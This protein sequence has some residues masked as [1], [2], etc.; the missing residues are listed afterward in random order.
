MKQ[1]EQDYKILSSFKREFIILPAV[2]I[3][4]FIWLKFTHIGIPCVFRLLT[5]WKCPGCGITH[6]FMDLFQGKLR[7]A[8]KENSFLMLTWPFIIGECIALSKLKR[9]KKK[10]PAWN[11][12]M[13]Y[14]YIAVACCFGVLRN[15][16]G[17]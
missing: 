9:E 12:A 3:A 1:S 16:Y 8:F 13:L 7:Q 5:G 2:C 14:V 4:Y 10:D 17:W 6:V 15:I 11:E